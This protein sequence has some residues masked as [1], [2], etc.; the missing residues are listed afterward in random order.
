MIINIKKLDLFRAIY[1]SAASNK[2]VRYYL[3]GV[4]IDP[5]SGIVTGT[6]GSILLSGKCVEIE[7]YNPDSENDKQAS[8]PFIMQLQDNIPTAYT[9]GYI[10]TETKTLT[11]YKNGNKKI[12]PYD[13]IDG[14]YP[15]YE[16]IIPDVSN[17][18]KGAKQFA[19]NPLL[20][21]PLLK[22]AKLS[23]NQVIFTFVDDTNNNGMR[24]NIA[25]LST[26]NGVIMPMRIKE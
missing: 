11:L 21:A 18:T 4:L 2:E 7:S 24:F 20:L 22:A 5:V 6:N 12:I 16:R 23:D 3:Q 26:H 8:Q 19:I 25:G 13:V 15:D 1:A 9:S 14:K 17:D 10:C